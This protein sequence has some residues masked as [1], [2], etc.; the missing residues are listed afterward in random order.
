[1]MTSNLELNYKRNRGL[2]SMLRFSNTIY[3]PWLIVAI[4]INFAAIGQ[5]A[6]MKLS[7]EQQEIWGLVESFW[8]SAHDGDLE[9]LMNLL[10]E[11][12]VYW[13][14][15]YTVTYNKSEMEFLFT[16]WLTHNRPKSYELS[17]RAIQ[18]IKN[19]AMV[20][21]FVNAKGNWGSESKRRT[22]VWMKNNGEWKL[23]GGMSAK[24]MP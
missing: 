15:G 18:I 23:I 3:I 4:A 6:E 17:V 19:V 14:E 5:A 2:F 8:E 12:Y 10:H 13:P 16:K 22:S 24:L 21:Y 9:D 1:M 11:K 20:H 7:Q